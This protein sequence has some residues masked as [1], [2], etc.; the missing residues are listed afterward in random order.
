MIVAEYHVNIL[1]SIAD[2]LDRQNE[3]ELAW[4]VRGMADST[5]LLDRWTARADMLGGAPELYAAYREGWR[6]CRE[7]VVR[8]VLDGMLR[9]GGDV[10]TET[11]AW[12]ARLL[13]ERQAR[14]EGTTNL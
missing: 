10:P 1:A 2:D 12:F 8:R 4:Y 6:A 9:G 5:Y 11:I 14:E 13:R 7:E 3:R